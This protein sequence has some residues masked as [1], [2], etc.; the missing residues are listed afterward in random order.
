MPSPEPKGWGSERLRLKQEI[1]LLRD[2]RDSLQARLNDL[3]MRDRRKEDIISRY[4]SEMI[5]WARALDTVMARQ[6]ID[7][8]L[9]EVRIE[10]RHELGDM[11]P[12][13]PT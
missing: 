5:R 8:A 7:I 12:G 10:I 13:L 4:Q 9:E 1:D 11:A 6:G 2:G 3:A